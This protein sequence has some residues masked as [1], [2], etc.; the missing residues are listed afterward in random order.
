MLKKKKKVNLSEAELDEKMKF[1]NEPCWYWS[2][3]VT[4]T[5]LCAPAGTAVPAALCWSPW[6][7][8]TGSGWWPGYRPGSHRTSSP[9]SAWPP[10]SSP[11]LCLS[12]TAR[13]PPSRS[14]IPPSMRL[15]QS[16]WWKSWCCQGAIF[17]LI[18]FGVGGLTRIQPDTSRRAFQRIHKWAIKNIQMPHLEDKLMHIGTCRACWRRRGCWRLVEFQWLW[19]KLRNRVF[20][21]W[22]DWSRTIQTLFIVQYKSSASHALT[23]CSSK[24]LD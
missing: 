24:K 5:V 23:R 3:W 8:A 11:P 19:R 20:L 17:E 10:M 21:C 6:C 7:S 22:C 12:T 13:L 15:L 4:L 1:S 16:N 9:S 14:A 18:V 2:R